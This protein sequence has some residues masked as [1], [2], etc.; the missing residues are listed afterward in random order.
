MNDEN[1]FPRAGSFSTSSR[2][3]VFRTRVRNRDEK[4]V[5]S[6][7][8][9]PLSQANMWPGFEA[10]HVFPRGYESL[11]IQFGYGHWVTDMDD[12]TDASKIDSVQNGLLMSRALHTCFE[13]Y[14]FSVNP[15]VGIPD[16]ESTAFPPILMGH[17]TV[18]RSSSSFQMLGELMG[19]FLIR[20]AVLLGT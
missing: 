7:V 17:R 9:N 2:E 20:S 3:E 16:I 10:A 15:D 18:I 14:L 1:W 19:D 12:T 13:Q 5:I 8:I 4:C 6:G 11:W